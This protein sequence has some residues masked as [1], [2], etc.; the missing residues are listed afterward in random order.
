M[1]IADIKLHL[2][3][4]PLS[5]PYPS[6]WNPGNPETKL[7]ISMVE[8]ITD[9]GIHGYAAAC[10]SSQLLAGI[11]DSHIKPLVI[12]K[13][14][15]Q[16]EEISTGLINAAQYAYRPWIVEIA[17]WDCLGKYCNLPIYKLLGGAKDRVLAYASTGSLKSTEERIED[18]ERFISEGFTMM[19]LRAHHDDPWE[20]LKVIEKVI[21]AA[22]GRIQF[23]VDANQ[24]W[25]FTGKKSV[26]KWDLKKAIRFAHELEDLGVIWLEEPLHQFDYEGLAELRASTS[27]SIAGGEINSHMHQ[28]R[29]FIK[30]GC[31]DIYNTDPTF[32]GGFHVAR[33]VTALIEAENKLLAPHT[34][35]HGYGLAASLQLAASTDCC[36]FIEYCYDPPAWEYTQRDMMLTEP[37]RVDSDGYITMSLKPGLG[38]DPNMELIDRYSVLKL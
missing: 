2:S 24:A 23:G 19:K 16:I 26:A 15:T 33:K 25:F 3:E 5:I 36:P 7:F 37:I 18:M 4:I 21:A 17:I 27:I 38:V 22:N 32:V 20:D 13:D 8:V 14:I 6:T 30:Y 28:F 10:D 12:G 1:K 35:T 9:D 29:D 31:Y 34:W 11:W